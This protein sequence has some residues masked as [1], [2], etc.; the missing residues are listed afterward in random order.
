MSGGVGYL[1][2][3]GAV[4]AALLFV[5]MVALVGLLRS[6]LEEY[7]HR[8][9]HRRVRERASSPPEPAAA[10]EP[11]FVAAPFTSSLE[12]AGDRAGPPAAREGEQP[13]GEGEAAPS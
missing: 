10:P 7:Q 4:W 9:R 2:V 6:G 11:P 3:T 13:P 5:L 1:I 8:Q 12:G